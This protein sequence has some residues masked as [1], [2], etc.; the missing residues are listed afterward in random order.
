MVGGFGISFINLHPE[1]IL[2]V[3]LSQIRFNSTFNKYFHNIDLDV[4]SIQIDNQLFGCEL[5]VSVYP[6][7][8]AK[9]HTTN[10][11]NLQ[12]SVKMERDLDFNLLVFKVKKLFYINFLDCILLLYLQL[13]RPKQNNQFYKNLGINQMNSSSPLQTASDRRVL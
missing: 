5:P 11:S 6:S 12:I 3:S 9:K 10:T 1:E 2:F 7:P 8:Q 4:G 13:N